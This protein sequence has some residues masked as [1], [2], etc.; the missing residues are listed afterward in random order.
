MSR[1]IRT[2]PILKVTSMPQA[3]AFYCQRLG[4]NQLFLFQRQP[5]EPAYAGLE[6]DGQRLHLSTFPGDGTSG[7][8]VY[9][10]VD[11]IEALQAKLV[12]SGAEP[13]EVEI[14]TQDWGRREIYVRD[15]QGN[16]VRFGELPGS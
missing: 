5:D 8:S 7:T 3:L 11:D 15:G 1:I 13:S 2:I 10:D 12:A 4:F 14:L 9:I 6:Q 16:T